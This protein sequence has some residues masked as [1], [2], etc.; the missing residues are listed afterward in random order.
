ML[1]AIA[2][3]GLSGVV[4]SA[5]A[6]EAAE[7]PVPSAADADPTALIACVVVFALMVAAFFGYMWMQG[8]KN[9]DADQRGGAQP[10]AAEAQ[11]K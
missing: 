10:A 7:V 5:W 1:K 6:Q 2:G 9:K 11:V 4:W 8:R 3:I